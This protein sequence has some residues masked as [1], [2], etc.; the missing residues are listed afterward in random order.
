[1]SNTPQDYKNELLKASEA[2][3][4]SH[5]DKD[6]K[7]NV[8]RRRELIL[9]RIC[10]LK[11]KYLEF[12]GKYIGILVTVLVFAFIA[13]VAIEFYK[14]DS[15]ASSPTRWGYFTHIISALAGGIVTILTRRNNKN[16]K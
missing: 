13:A 16:D 7:M 15:P 12:I 3:L 5:L 14:L 11:L 2:E 6:R 4:D 1:M 9:D 10:D 8:H